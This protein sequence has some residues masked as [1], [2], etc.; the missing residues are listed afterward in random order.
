MVTE[1]NKFDD[2]KLFYRLSH[3]LV[4]NNLLYRLKSIDFRYKWMY[5]IKYGS[6]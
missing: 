1:F 4:D 3:E 6:C 5:F 2:Y